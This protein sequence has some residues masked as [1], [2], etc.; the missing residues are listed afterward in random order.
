M[1]TDTALEYNGKILKINKMISDLETLGFNLSN[2][3]KQIDDINNKVLN[4][5]NSKENSHEF[6]VISIYTNGI[7]ELTKLEAII[8]NNY[9]VYF[10]IYN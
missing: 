8:E 9:S 10:K 4:E 5:S 2:L 7:N 3:K 6:E 1:V